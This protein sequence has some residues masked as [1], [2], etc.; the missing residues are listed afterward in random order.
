MTGITPLKVSGSI[1]RAYQ[2]LYPIPLSD[3]QDNPNL[4]QNTGY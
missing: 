4:T 3:I 2:Q 1:W